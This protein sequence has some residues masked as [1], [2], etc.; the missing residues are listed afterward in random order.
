[1]AIIIAWSS[2]AA[3]AQIDSLA[4]DEDVLPGYSRFIPIPL[5]SV[6]PETSV[7]VGAIGVFFFR[8][9]NS[10]KDTQLSSIRA[11]QS[12][13]FR[14]QVK[15]RLSNDIFLNRNKHIISGFTEWLRFPL[16]FYGVGADTRNSNKEIY[17]SRLFNISYNYL[18]KIQ[19]GKY[20]GARVDRRDSKI[21]E[22][23]EGGL[24]EEPGLVSGSEGGLSQGIG[25]VGRHD[26]RDNLLCTKTGWLSEFAIT[27]YNDVLNSDFEFTKL[28]FDT[29]YFF[30]IDDRH[31]LGGQTYIEQNWGAPSFENLALMGG[32]FLMRGNFE[33]RFRDRSM[34][35]TQWEYRLP[36]GR[37]SYID[38]NKSM[39]FWDRF[40]M[41]GFVGVGSVQDELLKD[42]FR[43]LK[44]TGGVGLRFLVFPEER[45]NVRV[46]AGFGTQTPAFYIFV[47]EAF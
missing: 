45:I 31:V 1:M 12:Y 14:N 8:F 42:T 46:D 6:A 47:R 36:L 19:E 29:R 38:N 7:R 25:I 32:P 41:V 21:Q 3:Q 23:A 13:T 35:A 20:I 43:D 11:P 22:T 2:V 40:G 10:S 37:P 33:G 15:F 4:L 5:F 28:T 16:F 34:W 30:S 44:F 17:T 24:L 27:F 18:F 26:T 39:G 9:K